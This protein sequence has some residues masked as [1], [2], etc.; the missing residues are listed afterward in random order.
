MEGGVINQKLEWESVITPADSYNLDSRPMEGVTYLEHPAPAVY[1]DSWPMEGGVINQKLE[2]ESV[3]TPADSYTLDSRPMEGIT[4]LEHP[5]PAVYMDSWPME[6]A[7]YLRPHV[8]WEVLNSKPTLNHV[9][10]VKIVDTDAS[11][12]V[13][14]DL[15]ESL[16]PMSTPMT[17]LAWPCV[18]SSRLPTVKPEIVNRMKDSREVNMT[19]PESAPPTIDPNVTMK[20]WE[21]GVC[22]LLIYAGDFPQDVLKTNSRNPEAANIQHEADEIYT[23]RTATQTR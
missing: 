6:G 17:A 4:Y 8:D 7:S 21:D 19:L 2:W 9:A 12:D 3:I 11:D 15:P 18:N 20:N 23:G 13:N 10:N 5:A 14:T 22:R 16:T 1:L